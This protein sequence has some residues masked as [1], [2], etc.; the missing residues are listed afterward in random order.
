MY[1][2]NGVWVLLPGILAWSFYLVDCLFVL[3]SKP[4]CRFCGVCVIKPFLMLWLLAIHI[5]NVCHSNT[6][7]TLLCGFQWSRGRG[8]W[9]EAIVSWKCCGSLLMVLWQYFLSSGKCPKSNFQ[10][11]KWLES[12]CTQ[13]LKTTLCPLAQLMKLMKQLF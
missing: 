6:L 12:C 8:W 2:S 9:Q 11:A 1:Q 7:C 13:I 5:Q 4:T 10:Q 3:P